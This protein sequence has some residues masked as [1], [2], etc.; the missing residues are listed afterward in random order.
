MSERSDAI[1]DA[2]LEIE[3]LRDRISHPH[4]RRAAFIDSMDQ[5]RVDALNEAWDAISAL[6]ACQTKETA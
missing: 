2:L 3:Y 6:E 4:G 1:R 5:Q